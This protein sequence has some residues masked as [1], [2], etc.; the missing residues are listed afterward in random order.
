MALYGKDAKSHLFR[1]RNTEC[2]IIFGNQIG[3]LRWNCGFRWDAELRWFYHQNTCFQI[4]YACRNHPG[5]SLATQAAV[6]SLLLWQISL[7]RNWGFRPK[8]W[9]DLCSKG[10][11]NS[12]MPFAVLKKWLQV[13]LAPLWQLFWAA[14]LRT[15]SLVKCLSHRI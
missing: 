5:A 1:S 4:L 15:M 7:M 6:I 12:T 14:I 3:F 2:R 11:I 13:A 8:S 9:R 10:L